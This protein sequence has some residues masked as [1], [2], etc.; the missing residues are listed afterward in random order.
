M[1]EM[2]LR[3]ALALSILSLLAPAATTAAGQ[4]LVVPQGGTPATNSNATAQNFFQS[5]Q[6][7]LTSFDTNYTWV[8]NRLEFAVGAD[9]QNQIQ[10][11]NDLE[12]QYDIHGGNFGLG[13]RMRNA[14][15][16]GVVEGEEAGVEYAMVSHDD[17]RV[18]A[19]LYGGYDE[20]YDRPLIEPELD[21]RKKLTE[22]TF[23][24]I[25]VSEPVLIQKNLHNAL[26]PNIGIETGFTF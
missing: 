13:A 15:I 23:A 9:Y 3:G 17:T 26:T 21:L 4:S 5:A 20:Q 22:N 18:E 1:K 25:Y 24:G 8:S 2:I 7:Y 12:L 19:K 14:G 11:A 16:A 10:W 6:G